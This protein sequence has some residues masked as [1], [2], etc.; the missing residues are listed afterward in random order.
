MLPAKPAPARTPRES[1]PQEIITS[2][3]NAPASRVECEDVAVLDQQ[4]LG[5]RIAAGS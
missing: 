3:R 1:S 2:A 5:T 4:R